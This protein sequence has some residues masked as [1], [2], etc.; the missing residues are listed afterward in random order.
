MYWDSSRKIYLSKKEADILMS[1]AVIDI[2]GIDQLLTSY[3]NQVEELPPVFSL[4]LFALMRCENPENI[5]QKS[6]FYTYRK[7]M[8]CTNDTSK[9][10][11]RH[12]IMKANGDVRTIYSVDDYLC[13]QQSWI[14]HC[15][16]EKLQPS[17]YATAYIQGLSTKNNAIPHLNNDILVKLDIH[18]F[19]NSITFS[20]V[21]GMFANRT[22]YPK[23]VVTFLTKLCCYNSHLPQGACTSPYIANLCLFE[24][25]QVIG[26]YCQNRGITYTRYSDDM[27][28]SANFMEISDLVSFVRTSLRVYRLT[29]NEK[30]T[31]VYRRGD[32]HKVTGIICNNG[33]SVPAEYKRKIRQEMF[34]LSKNGVEEHIRRMGDKRFLKYGN[35]IVQYYLKNLLG[36]I[37]YVLS[38][39]PSNSPFVS[40]RREIIY[41]CKNIAS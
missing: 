40:Y 38:I 32:R 12:S 28:F 33:V 35:P 27:T 26:A 3:R 9:Y 5:C 23:P 17:K 7:L 24:F 41:L 13:L 25:D 22:W 34:F 21:Y 8:E 30:K 4:P 14:L 20:H 39:E 18:D 6:F 10:Y 11:H 2:R 31:R 16:L 19:F 15:I 36:R 1:Y 29:L 37:N